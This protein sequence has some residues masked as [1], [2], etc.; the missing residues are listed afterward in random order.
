MLKR[1]DYMTA[2]ALLMDAV[3]PV[4]TEWAALSESGGR[5]HRGDRKSENKFLHLSFP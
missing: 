3:E 4:G 5:K 2:R 1:P